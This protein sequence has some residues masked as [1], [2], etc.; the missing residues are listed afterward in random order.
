MQVNNEESLDRASSREDAPAVK[1]V[2][3][4]Q[5]PSGVAGLEANKF[6]GEGLM[7]YDSDSCQPRFSTSHGYRELHP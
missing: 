1:T 6:A 2:A 5:I 7:A 3:Q 4:P